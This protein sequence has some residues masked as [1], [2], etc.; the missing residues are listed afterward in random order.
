MN[1]LEIILFSIGLCF[2]SFIALFFIICIDI[3]GFKKGLKNAFTI[4]LNPIKFL[5]KEISLS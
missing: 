5:K 2:F 3:F 4:L 1:I